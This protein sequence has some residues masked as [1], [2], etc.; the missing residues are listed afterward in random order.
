MRM[1]LTADRKFFTIFQHK[2]DSYIYNI[3][4]L[5]F[6]MNYTQNLLS[7][8]TEPLHSNRKFIY[9]M[10]KPFHNDNEANAI[11]PLI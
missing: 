4:I 5:I 7:V 9:C 6:P 10:L 11:F 1:T 8:Q 3:Y 2:G